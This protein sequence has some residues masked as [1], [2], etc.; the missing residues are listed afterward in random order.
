MWRDKRYICKRQ[1]AVT[2]GN[3]HNWLK[4]NFEA[5]LDQEGFLLSN[6]VLK[7]ARLARQAHSQAFRICK[8]ALPAGFSISYGSL[9]PVG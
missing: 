5:Q 6:Y 2:H 7:I 1:K 3:K 8:I 9:P 4:A